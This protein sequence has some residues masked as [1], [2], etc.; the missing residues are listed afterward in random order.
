MKVIVFVLAGR[1][2]N[3]ELQLPLMRR[4]LERHP[5]VVYHIW[6]LSR[7]QTDNA[8]L[9]T[10]KGERITVV[11]SFYGPNPSVR[12]NDVY[13]HYAQEKYANALFVKM[14]DDVVFLET[15]RFGE[16]VDI[17]AAHPKLVCSAKVINNGACTH[18]EPALYEIVRRLRV[19][20][21]LHAPVPGRVQTR[22]YKGR[23]TQI[24]T[25][26][27]PLPL[28]DVHL[29]LDYARRV[30]RYAIDHF[31]ELTEQ[32]LQLIPSQD[33]L[34]INL[35][36]HNHDM[37]KVLASKV[38]TAS[39]TRIAGRVMGPARIGDEG[40]INT[41]QRAIVGGF[42]A[43]HL[44]FGVQHQQMHEREWDRLRHQYRALGVQYLRRTGEMYG[45]IPCTE[46][47]LSF[48][49]SAASS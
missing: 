33:W 28:L 12:I 3:M 39:P 23:P 46:Q 5:N 6:N 32:P 7:Q 31:D 20:V 41:L 30:H 2:A 34:S 22:A 49:E 43:V 40:V 15:E 36:G 27:A 14:D 17:V 24:L 37:M 4:V 42:T 8:W 9:R 21:P 47:S 45:D 16:F 10:I 44:S 26:N 48:S 13:R 35:I 18:Q 1:R 19:K 38:G 11:N 29:N 25:K